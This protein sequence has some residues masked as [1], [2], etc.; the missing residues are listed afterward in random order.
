M[1]SVF[2]P[3]RKG[4]ERVPNK[5]TKEFAL[6]SGGLLRLKLN[7]LIECK[8]ISEIILSTN[9]DS[10]F[11]V[12]K[13]IK[14]TKLKIIKRPEALALSTTSLIDLVKYVPS[15]CSYEH[16]LWTH[17]TSPFVDSHDYDSIIEKYLTSINNGYDSLMS[18]KPLRNYLWDEQQRDII[19]RDGVGKWPR[20]Q[21][22][23]IFYEI[24]SAVFLA[25][26]EIYKKQT[27]RIGESPFLLEMDGIKSFDVDW[28]E[29]FKVAEYIYNGINKAN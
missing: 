3:T 25:S 15:I 24:N 13:S 10:S 5:N 20:T 26:K 21:D 7:Q 4:S 27:D 9:D 22:L 17:V 2:L 29:D 18:V 28:E 16:I 19:N 12:A 11:E 14:D 1:I 8:M 6:I 23:K